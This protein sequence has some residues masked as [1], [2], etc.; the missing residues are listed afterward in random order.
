MDKRAIHL[1]TWKEAEEKFKENPVVLIP[2]GS[3]EEHGPQ[4][5]TG[6]F[7][8]A[9]EVAQR[10]AERTDTLYTPTVPFGNSEYFR[11][12][13]G[14]ITLSQETIEGLLTDIV[15]SLVHHKINKIVFINGHAGNTSAINNVARDIKR[16]HDV[17]II[18][19]NLWQLLTQSEKQD[20]YNEPDPSGHGGEP[21]TSIMCYLYPEE[22]R[23][24]L[25][26]KTWEVNRDYHGLNLDSLV[27][28]S[29][30]GA[31][32][33]VFIN[34]EEVSPEGILGNPLHANSERGEKIIN[35]VV[36]HCS[37]IVNKFKKG[38]K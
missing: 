25:L 23:M 14:T 31:N 24:D 27:G 8:A 7:L 32:A 22:M 19:I 5:I 18:S 21:L 10:V 13:P 1:M 30:S 26:P 29:S 9:K 15:I 3:M 17:T 37:N 4:S 38:G 35:A 36:N 16:D 20:I 34:M 11:N 6:D 33:N 12:Y 2:L 28:A